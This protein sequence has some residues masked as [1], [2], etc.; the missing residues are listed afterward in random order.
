LCAAGWC[1]RGHKDTSRWAGCPIRRRRSPLNYQLWI[2]V[3]PPPRH[4][5]WPP[6]LVA[7]R[8]VDGFHRSACPFF[9]GLRTLLCTGSPSEWIPYTSVLYGP[10]TFPI[11]GPAACPGIGLL[12]S[13]GRFSMTART[14]ATS[15]SLSIATC[16]T[17]G[18]VWF[19]A[20]AFL[21]LLPTIDSQSH[22]VGPTYR[23]YALSPIHL[24]ARS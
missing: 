19:G 21:P 12:A 8:A 13:V 20:D 7:E 23:R 16:S 17:C 10:K 5:A 2:T 9:R 22:A 15:L 14:Y 11:L 6:S 3:V 18:A 4:T 1:S 24:G